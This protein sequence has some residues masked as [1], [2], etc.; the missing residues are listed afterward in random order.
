MKRIRPQRRHLK[1]N[2]EPDWISGGVS[3]ISRIPRSANNPEKN[4]DIGGIND[5]STTKAKNPSI[6]EE[7]YTSNISN[8]DTPTLTASS[9]SNFSNSPTSK[10][11]RTIAQE[12]FSHHIFFW[13]YN[14]ATQ[15]DSYI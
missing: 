1:T 2:Q 7:R 3:T 15:K 11:P 9:A 6:L 4:G 10:T 12:S 5:Q 13:A 8:P 14:R